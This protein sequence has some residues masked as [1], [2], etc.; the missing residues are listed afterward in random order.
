MRSIDLLARLRG[1]VR[2]AGLLPVRGVKVM[3]FDRDG[4]VLLVRHRYGDRDAWMLPGGG[5]RPWE[6]PIAA[7]QRE[8][9]E[10]TGCRLD[11]PRLVA[12]FR[13][14][15][16]GVMHPLFL[17]AG[18]TGNVP[19]PDGVEIAEAAFFDP[20]VLPVGVSPATRRRLNEHDRPR[21]W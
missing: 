16:D 9:W 17:F 10:E 18:A 5:V 13:A 20:A 12:S 2:R 1:S 19:V 7:A 3:T 6:R 4:R 15:A 8:L 11:D 21:D 14:V